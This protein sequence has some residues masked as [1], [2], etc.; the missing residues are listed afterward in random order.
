M[1]LTFWLTVCMCAH[2]VVINK[3][4]HIHTRALAPSESKVTYLLHY[5]PLF[6][7]EITSAQV[8]GGARQFKLL[9]AS[10]FAYVIISEGARGELL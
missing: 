8:S 10:I 1:V 2:A 5:L 4:I 9:S 7:V 6:I 3:N